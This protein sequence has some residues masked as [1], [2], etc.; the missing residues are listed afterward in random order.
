MKIWTSPKTSAPKSHYAWRSFGSILGKLLFA[1]FLLAGSV[2]L[3]L[4]PNAPKEVILTLSCV[5]I[6]GLILWLAIGAGRR[7]QLDSTIFW[8][9]SRDQLFVLDVRQTVPYNKGIL[10]YFTMNRD[11]QKNIETVKRQLQEGFS[12][13]DESAQILQV[14]K[15]QEYSRYYILVC[16]AELGTGARCRL[17]YLLGK[18]WP[19]EQELLFILE[20]KRFQENAFEPKANRTPFRIFL[21]AL[22]FLCLG[23]VCVLSHPAVG[24]L[25]QE[26]Y[27]PCLGLSL[28]PLYSLIYFLVKHHRGE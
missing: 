18:G 23:A 12:P 24:K 19:N 1:L 16:K 27:F 3:A 28:I 4:R 5:I 7:R 25:S 2:F 15:I 26:I 21:S 14:E 13:W 8:L 10:G 9:D 20:R 11:I 22:A 6:T 17:T